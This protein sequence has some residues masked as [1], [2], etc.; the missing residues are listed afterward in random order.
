MH[1]LKDATSQVKFY[2]LYGDEQG[3]LDLPPGTIGSFSGGPKSQVS[4]FAYTSFTT[5]TMVYRFDHFSQQAQTFFTPKLNIDPKQ[6][7]TEQVFV[8]SKDGSKIPAF[9]IYAPSNLGQNTEPRP[10]VLYG[11]GG[12]NISLSPY[13]KPDLL[14]W[15][16]KG[17]MY[18]IANLRGGGEYGEAWHKAG[19]RDQ[20]QNVFDDFI[21]VAEWLISSKKTELTF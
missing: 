6:F 17:G 11:Y 21:A 12:F 8:K 14:P 4:Y 15:L 18:V 1:Y 19:M 10:T 20:K 16:Q 5:P 7:K 3:E 2:T 9:L 13:F